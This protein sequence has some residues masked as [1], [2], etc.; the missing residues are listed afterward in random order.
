MFMLIKKARRDIRSPV[1]SASIN[2]ACGLF[3][4]RKSRSSSVKEALDLFMALL[5]PQDRKCVEGNACHENDL[6]VI[7]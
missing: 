6:L 2:E 1:I 3:S 4:L 5:L 7:E